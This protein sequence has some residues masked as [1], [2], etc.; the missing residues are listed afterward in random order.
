MPNE[1]E[2]AYGLPGSLAPLPTFDP[3]GL[4]A[5]KTLDEV[6]ML[7]EAEV[8]H[9]RVSMLAVLGFLMQEERHVLF[10]GPEKDIGPAIRHLD[11]VNPMFL[12]L[13]ALVITCAELFRSLCGWV[14][15]Y[16]LMFEDAGHWRALRDDYYPGDIGFDPLDLKP[17]GAAAF[18]DM[19]T[20]E[21]QNGR[22][23]MLAIAG[24]V[25]Q[26]LANGKTIFE[27]LGATGEAAIAGG[28]AI[29]AASAVSFLAGGLCAPQLRPDDATAVPTSAGGDVVSGGRQVG[30]QGGDS[31]AGVQGGKKLDA[32]QAARMWRVG[33]ASRPASRP[34]GN[35]VSGLFARTDEENAMLRRKPRRT[36]DAIADVIATKDKEIARQA[37]ELAQLRAKLAKVRDKLAKLLRK[38]RSTSNQRRRRLRRL[39]RHLHRLRHAGAAYPFGFTRASKRS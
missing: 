12:K 24:F 36:G 37:V 7:R 19:A 20:K 13:L 16:A 25:A 23:A 9:G 26:E 5:G 31:K 39:R 27:D 3:A 2:F 17:E 18:A 15:P 29:A 8:T 38:I 14:S 11:A 21:L 1:N 28:P 22:L 32:R 30:V 33:P 34:A 4:A 35:A 6:K 10:V